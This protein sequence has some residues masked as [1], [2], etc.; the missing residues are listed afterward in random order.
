MIW[1]EE[2]FSFIHQSS[3]LMHMNLNSD[4]FLSRCGSISGTQA[5]GKKVGHLQLFSIDS[6]CVIAEFILKLF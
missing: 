4:F 2:D 1:A 3:L 6:V 5:D